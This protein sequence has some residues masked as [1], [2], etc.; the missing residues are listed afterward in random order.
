MPVRRRSAARSNTGNA[1]RMNKKRRIMNNIKKTE[2]ALDKFVEKIDVSK[3][4]GMPEDSYKAG[5]AFVENGQ[6]DDGIIEFVKIIK[7]VPHQ[8]ALFAD[9]E[10]EL[11]SMG[12]SDIDIRAIAGIPNSEENLNTTLVSDDNAQKEDTE[13]NKKNAGGLIAYYVF[14]L[15]A[16]VFTCPT[17]FW[18]AAVQSNN[19]L[20][21]AVIIF[22]F[23]LI[24]PLFF[25]NNK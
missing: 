2:S 9:A 17:V 18:G 14:V 12:F 7:T 24:A 15:L 3:P 22:I 21:S 20:Y 8:E 25:G 11:K 5:L 1:S 19:I 10:K 6:F 13:T 23:L 4:E 16:A